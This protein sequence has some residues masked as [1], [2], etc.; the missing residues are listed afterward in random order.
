MIS[1]TNKQLFVFLG[2]VMRCYFNY[3]DSESYSFYTIVCLIKMGLRNNYQ[4]IFFYYSLFNTIYT[5]VV[6]INN[7][8]Q[9]IKNVGLRIYLDKKRKKKERKTLKLVKCLHYAKIIHPIINKVSK[10][11]PPLS[12]KDTPLQYNW[13]VLWQ[14]C[15]PPLLFGM[16]GGARSGSCRPGMDHC[17]W[18]EGEEEEKTGRN[19]MEEVE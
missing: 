6:L 13:S 4:I 9:N 16:V 5:N 14:H 10:Q 7:R 1:E 17:G 19:C 12:W 3:F 15:G 2:F 18:A 11:A 8:L